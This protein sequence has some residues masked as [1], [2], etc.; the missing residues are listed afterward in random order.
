MNLPKSNEKLVVKLEDVAAVIVEL[1]SIVVSLHQIG[2]RYAI[3]G[4]R[5]EYERET[6]RF[7]DEWCVTQRLAAANALLHT[8]FDRTL[9]PDDMD[10]LERAAEVADSWEGPASTPKPETV[11]KG[12]ALSG[13]VHRGEFP[14]A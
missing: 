5:E 4:D 2:A 8:P 6:L 7:I 14:V 10:D 13:P 12:T 1:S 9:G 11:A 3:A